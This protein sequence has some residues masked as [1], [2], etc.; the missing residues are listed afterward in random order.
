[1]QKKNIMDKKPFLTIDMLSLDKKLV[2]NL[3]GFTKDSFDPERIVATA[4]KAEI[5][6]LLQEELQGPSKNFVKHFAS[7]VYSGSLYDAQIQHFT[8][9]TK[10]A[11]GDLVQQEIASHLPEVEP[12]PKK[13]EVELNKE[14]PPP[15]PV[16]PLPELPVFAE[17]KGQRFEGTLLLREK[18]S[19]LNRINFRFES[20][21][22]NHAKAADKARK[23]INPDARQSIGWLFWIFIHPDTKEELPIREVF[24]N[25]EL[26]ARL[27]AKG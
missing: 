6:R 1:M 12:A 4:Q 15:P 16:P 22:T 21:E 8:K 7:Q 2:E 25:S 27:R 20:E 14:T 24:K 23:S 9:L 17:Y 10:E 5:L 13:D 11:W 26:L 3:Q 18:L 19:D